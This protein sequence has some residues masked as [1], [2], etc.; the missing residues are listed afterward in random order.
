MLLD[1]VK[2]GE[3]GIPFFYNLPVF[4]Y[5]LTLLSVWLN[6]MDL[7]YVVRTS[8]YKAQEVEKT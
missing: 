4:Y 8:L 7:S 5:G 6:V 2:T 3:N 1:T